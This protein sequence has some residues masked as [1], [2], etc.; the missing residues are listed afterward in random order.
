MSFLDTK[1][2]LTGFLLTPVDE[3]GKAVSSAYTLSKQEPLLMFTTFLSS[4]APILGRGISGVVTDSIFCG[5]SPVP[6]HLL[7]FLVEPQQEILSEDSTVASLSW[8]GAILRP[9]EAPQEL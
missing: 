6:Q 3:D 7:C 8:P 9:W 2:W 5:V 4:S 1:T